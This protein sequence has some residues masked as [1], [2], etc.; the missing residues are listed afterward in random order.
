MKLAELLAKRA[1]GET[2]TQ[3]ELD[4][5]AEYDAVVAVQL[6]ELERVKAEKEES[7]IKLANADTE[8]QAKLKALSDKEVELEEERKR[9]AKEQKE[10]EDI[11]KILDNSKSTEEAKIAIEKAKAEKKRAE[12]KEELEKAN[13]EKLRK[14]QEEKDADNAEK[15]KLENELATL[16]F[17]RLIIEERTKRPYITN[18]LDTLLKDLPN[19]GVAEATLHLNVLLSL[20]NHEEEMVK[21]RDKQ[22]ADTDIF[23]KPEVKEELRPP[24][25]VDY[26]SDEEII[27]LAKKLGF[28]TRRPQK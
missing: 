22:K 9:L 18:Q 24:K 8:L 13:A 5:L 2:L 21:Y 25:Q 15:K 16:K 23:S 26:S 27:A 17:E 7:D 20:Y 3:E 11:Q 4:F 12:D 19:K 6:S 14:I 10:K 28:K 1:K